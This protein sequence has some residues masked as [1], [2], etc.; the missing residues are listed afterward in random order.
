MRVRP[1][2]V[3]LRLTLWYS[4]VLG[5]IV[6]V[7]CGFVYLFVQARLFRQIDHQLRANL[8][9]LAEV[10]A[11]EPEEV[12]EEEPG[13]SPGLY[14]VLRQGSVYFQTPAYEK[15]GL[16]TSHLPAR[17]RAVTI[18]AGSGREYRM[19]TLAGG[20]EF[21]LAVA[22]SERPI[23]KTLET[24]LVI[25]MAALPLAVVL[26]A[27]GG[28][29]MA[30]RLLRPVGAMTDQAS[31]I[32]EAN[33]SERLPIA[34]P[35]DEFGR[36]AVVIN[37][38]FSR[39]ESSFSRLK[40]FTADA[41]HELRTPLTA[42]QSVGEVALGEDLDVAGYR[43]RI[44]SMLEETA[45]LTRLVESLLLLT[46]ADRG[47]LRPERRDS[48]LT[49]LVDKVVED[50]RVMAEEKAQSLRANLEK[51]LRARFDPDTLRLAVANILDN[52]VKYT[53]AGGTIVV[54]LARRPEG[55]VIEVT[56]SGPGIPAEQRAKV[57]DRFYRV[58][59]DRSQNEGGVGLG[60]AIAKWA[61]E[62]NGGR[63]QL[64]SE[65]GKGSTFR[66]VLPVVAEAGQ[67]LG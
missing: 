49:G 44:G 60:L 55:L 66:I 65:E 45:R 51:G 32:G 7:L 2:S 62:I 15:A 61:V 42:I 48:D 10:T 63:I 5:L 50:L 58:G 24:L 13:E 29:I 21:D 6:I 52:A 9:T 3:R 39:L 41:S 4:L 57:F 11:R 34:N 54:G 18:K 40:R 26:S 56:D 38:T 53:P 64:E 27:V 30:G 8:D 33:L 37:Q 1:V 16:P 36:L 59:K 19:M 43:D 46:R 20:K 35:D 23:R 28:S 47:D 22:E 12:R 31:R 67:A 25:L 17:G 14:L